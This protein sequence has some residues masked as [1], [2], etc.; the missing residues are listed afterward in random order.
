LACCLVAVE[1]A[2]LLSKAVTQMRYFVLNELRL[3]LDREL[4]PKTTMV[5]TLYFC[6]I[7]ISICY[8]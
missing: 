3:C 2:Y 1:L 5:S 4:N 7:T 8:S 6:I